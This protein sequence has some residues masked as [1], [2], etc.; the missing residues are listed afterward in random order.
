MS[1]TYK[2]TIKRVKI[3]NTILKIIFKFVNKNK[4][5]ETELFKL[6]FSDCVVAFN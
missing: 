4:F 1:Y 5:L 2:I 3:G 6:F